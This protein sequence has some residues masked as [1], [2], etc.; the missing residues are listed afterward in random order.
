VRSERVNPP[1][2]RPRID[3]SL[4]AV[5]RRADRTG[6][7]TRA[8]VATALATC[9]LPACGRIGYDLLAE[10]KGPSSLDAGVA[11]DGSAEAPA[12]L[13]GLADGAVG[14]EDAGSVDDADTAD[15]ASADV[16][17]AYP[18]DAFDAT[19]ALADVAAEAGPDADAMCMVSTVTDYCSAIPPLLAPPVIDGVLDCGPALVPV[20]PQDWS[21]PSP[22]PPFPPGNSCELAAAWRPD[23]LYVFIAVTTPAYF[24]ADTGSPI[25]DGAGVE[26]FVDNDGVY[27]NAPTYDNPGTIQFIVPA[28]P[29]GATVSTRADGLRNSVDFETWTSSQFGVYPTPAGFTF[30]GFIGA[31]DLGLTSWSLASGSA[32][33]FDIAIDVSYTTSA[34]TGTQ[35]HRV[36]Q[37]FFHVAPPPVGDAAAIGLPFQDPRAFCTPTLA[38]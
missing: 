22:L 25:Y 9:A 3:V 33:G 32:I 34:Q 35:G 26:I 5:P 4:E 37:Y 13:D 31:A 10:A 1:A 24:P 6:S 14:V 21:G 12:S 7:R 17:D 19:D 28:P 23:G 16:L 2:S 15:V 18:F 11:R 36:G 38:P 29:S 30:E 8:I 27:A 20:T